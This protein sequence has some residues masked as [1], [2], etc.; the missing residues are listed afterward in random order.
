MSAARVQFGWNMFKVVSGFTGIVS[1]I[2]MLHLFRTRQIAFLMISAA[3]TALYTLLAMF[4]SLRGQD[5][6]MQKSS[7]RWM[8]TVEIMSY[9]ELFLT[10]LTCW[11]IGDMLFRNRKRPALSAPAPT[12]VMPAPAYAPMSFPAF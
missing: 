3:Y 1:A 8:K 2:A 11:A 5:A 12:S 9:I 10:F 7:K 4:A 6:T